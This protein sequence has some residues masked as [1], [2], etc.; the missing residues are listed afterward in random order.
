MSIKVIKF[1]PNK[2]KSSLLSNCHEQ[3]SRKYLYCWITATR[4]RPMDID[5]QPARISQHHSHIRY[6]IWPEYLIGTVQ[7]MSPLKQNSAVGI[8][9]SEMPFL[10]GNG[11]NFELCNFG[12]IEAQGRIIVVLLNHI[13]AN[14]LIGLSVSSK[15]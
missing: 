5:A 4:E 10:T 9:S 7:K 15:T 8:R 13:P 11:C 12:D 2:N 3:I 6:N 1:L 14:V